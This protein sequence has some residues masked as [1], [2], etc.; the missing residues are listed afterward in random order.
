[1]DERQE[2]MEG[3]EFYRVLLDNLYDGVFYVSP[4]RTILYWNDAAKRLTGYDKSEMVG[5]HCWDNLLMD[6]DKNGVNLCLRGCL[7]D[8][9]I[10][11]G[12]MVEGEVYLHHKEGH[13]VPV[14]VRVSPIFDASGTVI[15]AVEV[16]SDNSPRVHLAERIADLEKLALLD[17]L[18][19]IGNRRYGELSLSAR[20]NEFD[21]YVWSFGVLLMDI[22]SFKTIQDDFGNETADK[23]LKMVSA[24]MANGIRSCDILSRW[25][26]EEFIALIPNV[27]EKQLALVANK[28]RALVE[29]SSLSE[30]GNLVKV[31][32]SVGACLVREGDTSHSLIARAQELVFR[33]KSDGPNRLTM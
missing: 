4:E 30:D 6:V 9:S 16:F 27:D 21:R 10:S 8:K 12:I 31:T 13:R 2:V 17:P 15:G 22:D 33:G 25:S 23:V 5:R 18:T 7:L 20:L 28:L 24:T 14:L 11:E 3:S 29:A 19:R 1:M 32:I 26:G